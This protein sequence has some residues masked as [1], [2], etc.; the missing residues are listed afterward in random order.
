MNILVDGALPR[1]LASYVSG[2]L[3]ETEWSYFVFSR[4]EP[5]ERRTYPVPGHRYR[6]RKPFN[7]DHSI[8]G[9]PHGLE[10]LPPLLGGALFL[11]PVA[12][13]VLLCLAQLGGFLRDHLA[14]LCTASARRV[15]AGRGAGAGSRQ[16][17]A[18]PSCSESP[19]GPARLDMMS[20]VAAPP[21][22]R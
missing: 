16:R 5:L 4:T 7:P 11:A 19:P 14:C 2:R 15:Q 13:R 1:Q 3:T 12:L 22:C 6:Y 20:R 21:A 10:L 9:V 17:T 8:L 18:A